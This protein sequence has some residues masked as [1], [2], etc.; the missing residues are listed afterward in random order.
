MAENKNIKQK[1][2]EARILLKKEN[3][4][5]SGKNS[6]RNT[7]DKRTSIKANGWRRCRKTINTSTTWTKES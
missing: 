7:N 5:K 1:L 3:L 2:Q 6:T 4:T